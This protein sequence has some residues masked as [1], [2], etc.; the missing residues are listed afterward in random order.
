[1]AG[2]LIYTLSFYTWTGQLWV[3]HK[4]RGPRWIWGERTLFIGW[5][6]LTPAV[7]GAYELWRVRKWRVLA[8]RV[9]VIS[10]CKL[11]LR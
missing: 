7:I 1:M 3:V 11:R 10:L 9:V 8:S 6:A 2:S 5:V 4:G